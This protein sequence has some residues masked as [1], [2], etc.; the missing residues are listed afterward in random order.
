MGRTQGQIETQ[1]KGLGREALAY[2]LDH[3][4]DF[5]EDCLI[6]KSNYKIS[7]QQK[8]FLNELTKSNRIAVRSGHGVG[9]TSVLS[10][11]GSWFLTTRPFSIIP[12]TAGTYRQVKDVLWRE[13]HKWLRDSCLTYMLDW[14]PEKICNLNHKEDWY[15]I[16]RSSKN[17]Q[18]LQGY[19]DEHEMFLI[20]EAA[21]VPDDTME[22]IEFS[23]DKPDNYIIKVGNPTLIVGHFYNSFH[24]DSAGW[25]KLHFNAEE[26]PITSKKHIA[27]LAQK[28][29]KNSDVYLARVK[30]EFPRG[31]PDAFLQ[32][33]DV[34][35][36]EQREIEYTTDDP[37]EMGVDPARFGD[38]LFTVCT[39]AGNHTFPIAIREKIDNVAGAAFVIDEL[40]KYRKLTGIKSTV[41]IKVDHGEG[42]GVIDILRTNRTDN[43]EVIEVNF[44]G[45][46]NEDYSNCVS[47][48]F[49]EFRERLPYIDLP[50]DIDMEAELATR[51]KRPTYDSPTEIEDKA[52]F[53]KRYGQSPDRADAVLMCHCNPA[54]ENKVIPYFDWKKREHHRNY[55][56]N[57]K[58]LDRVNR[59]GQRNR[60]KVYAFAYQE[61][62]L[63]T[64]I[65]CALWS[66][67]SGH[68][69]P[70]WEGLYESPQPEEISESMKKEFKTMAGIE[71]FMK[72]IEW[73]C[74]S[75]MVGGTGDLIQAKDEV[76]SVADQFA[77]YGINLY[78]DP[79]YNEAASVMKINK[80]FIKS[81]ITVH[82]RCSILAQQLRDWNI[83][84]T[85]PS[86]TE[87]GFCRALAVG[88]SFLVKDKKPGEKDKPPKEYTMERQKDRES[89]VK[90]D[91]ERNA[92][93]GNKLTTHS[94]M[95]V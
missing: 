93:I 72:R 10:W 78:A 87:C 71:N 32:L 42:S 18:N 90:I 51:R 65:L 66:P 29:G 54:K 20:D 19:H 5:V 76:D 58:A 57:F 69:Y 63:F 34:A 67:A 86:D 46:G 11:A 16:I 56:I 80:M 28:W 27:R 6:R 75:P 2:Y 70:F 62:T 88:V 39:R 95:A 41:R 26:S 45:K 13:W 38:D 55:P 48:M 35:A 14:H 53:K 89:V 52:S 64:S 9:K 74:N 40:R 12:C 83:E 36:A 82:E 31:N 21:G 43:I 22:I 44:G 61:K 73:I 4:V 91:R 47:A 1:A 79:G 25:S 49:G 84:N 8:D 81:Q 7:W 24:G 59:L 60:I 68:L 37:L 92:A 3:P 30:G 94:W 17:A 15:A 85:R 50:Q 23:A 33:V 77:E